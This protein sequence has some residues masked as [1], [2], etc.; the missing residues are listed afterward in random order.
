MHSTYLMFLLFIE[1]AVGESDFGALIELKKG[2][3]KDP[4]EVLDSWDSKS[5][6][7]DGCPENWFGI[8]CSEG[9]VTSITLNDLGI[10]GDFH[11]TAITGLKML[12]NLLVSNNLFTGLGTW[13]LQIRF[14]DSVFEY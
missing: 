13:K 8:I 14:L 11:F 4:S 1:L 9:Y 12:Q 5:L 2:I 10:V 7:F 3:Q 6:A